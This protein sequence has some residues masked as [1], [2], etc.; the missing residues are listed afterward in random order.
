MYLNLYI[1]RVNKVIILTQKIEGRQSVGGHYV[2]S[3]DSAL[4]RKM[5][6]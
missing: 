6:V 2:S 4:I 3:L 1:N 5:M